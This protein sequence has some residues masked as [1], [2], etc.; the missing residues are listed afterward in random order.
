MLR[1]NAN[2]INIYSLYNKNEEICFVG[3]K[4]EC[5][6]YMGCTTNAFLTSYSRRT[7][8]VRKYLIYF[9]EAEPIKEKRC[10]KCG[11]VKP[12]EQFG[13]RRN[14]N[15]TWIPVAI[16]KECKNKIQKEL[17]ERKCK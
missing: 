1:K 2:T 12:I 9:V 10:S 11:K 4:Q 6:E 13:R 3:T 14:R 8:C 16:C 17:K 5:C 7:Y 15:G